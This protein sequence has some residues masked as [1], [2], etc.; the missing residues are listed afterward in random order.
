M[1]ERGTEHPPAAIRPAGLTVLYDADCPVCR[2]ARRWV[3]RHR[4][5]VPVRFV[6]AGSIAARRRFPGLDVGST[7]ESVTA[8]TDEGAVLRGD[9]AWIAVLW[10]VART[11]TLAI[12]L[13]SGRSSWRLRGAMTAADAIRQRAHRQRC[14]GRTMRTTA[15]TAGP[16]PAH[17]WPP[18]RL[19]PARDCVG[20]DDFR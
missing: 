9:Q 4:Q 10:S 1:T 18:P 2:N 20:C 13:A 3:E 6:P 16:T 14:P 19:A 17:G 12:K 15:T 5:L 11:R 7:L 8:I